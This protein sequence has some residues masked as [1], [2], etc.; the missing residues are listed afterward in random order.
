MEIRLI[1]F[2]AFTSLTL[3]FNSFVIWYAYKAYTKASTIVTST[4]RDIGTSDGAQAWVKALEVASMHAVSV[5]QNA[6]ADLIQL[7][8]IVARVQE[9]Y[10]FKLAEI[11][12]HVEKA[13]SKVLYHTEAFQNA[14]EGPTRKLAATLAGV[15]EVVQYF[16]G[17]R[18]T[19]QSESDATSTPKP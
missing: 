16:S 11:D 17:E 8:P 5:T 2:L 13:I 4:I 1:I 12:V 10:E 19:D 14:V 15:S 9:S 7:D 3:I 18:Q 6:K